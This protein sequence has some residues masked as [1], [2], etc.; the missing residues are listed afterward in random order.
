MIQKEIERNNEEKQK[1]RALAYAL[2]LSS[3]LNQ[4]NRKNRKE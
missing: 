1:K 3:N 2:K 4:K